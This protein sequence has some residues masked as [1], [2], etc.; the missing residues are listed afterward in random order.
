MSIREREPGNRGEATTTLNVAG[1]VDALALPS[2]EP[3]ATD[4]AALSGLPELPVLGE[5]GP[6]A[7]SQLDGVRALMDGCGDAIAALRRHQNRCAAEVAIMV[8]RMESTAVL[9]GKL[10]SLDWWQRGCAIDQ[11]TSELAVL[12]QVTE[13]VAGRLIEQSVTLVRLLP[14][15]LDRLAEGDL[16]WDHAVV[17]A[18]EA[19]LL[20]VSGVCQEAIDAFEKQLL[21]L[22]TN[23]TLPSFKSTARRIRERSHPESIVA[24]TRRSYADRNLRVNRGA[25]GM[26]WMALYAPSPTIEAIWDQCTYTAQAAQGADEDRTLTQLK[27]DIC[28]ALLLRQS[29]AENSIHSPARTENEAAFPDFGSSG[30][31]SRDEASATESAA[32]EAASAETAAGE[33]AA[34]ETASAASG[35]GGESVPR[36]FGPEPD[37]CGD[38]SCAD[39]GRG[40]SLPS[41]WQIPV[42]DDPDYTVSGFVE[43]DPRNYPDWRPVA[44]LPVLIPADP[45]VEAERLSGP[46]AKSA[47]NPSGDTTDLWPPLPQVTPVVLIPA[48]SLLGETNEPAWMDG[49]GPISMEVAKRMAVQAGSFLRVLVDPITNKPLDS[50]PDRYR[51]DQAMR[52]MLLIR[53]E[54]C[55]FPGCTAKAINC[56][57]DHIKSFE[58]GGR[59]I[60]NNLEHLCAHHHLVKHYK[61]DKDRTGTRR[62]IDEPERQSLRLRGWTPRREDDGRVSWTSPAGRY[63]PPEANEERNPAYPGWLK[64][65]IDGSLSQEVDG[66]P[67]G[68]PGRPSDP[69]QPDQ[70][71]Q[72]EEFASGREDDDILT[73]LALQRGLE[74]P[75]LGCAEAA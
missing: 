33:T 66:A 1:L 63:C 15:T 36:Y 48:L 32:G 5:S 26:S 38:G 47:C 54:Y 34:G 22:A 6:A 12:L 9:E 16:A 50:A 56:D 62:C 42:F 60:Y 30:S 49:A 68:A 57:V 71:D 18:E 29:M 35:A 31:S 24:R 40:D 75:W 11:I 64:G 51:I 46:P 65:V 3:L 45:P 59:S 58:S 4:I 7:W 25:D 69:N 39:Q 70:P 10:L 67:A 27:A 41:D 52:T 14:A 55:E 17:I 73:Q 43:P 23:K 53:D 72:P 21:G 44:Q 28:A 20:R 8:E 61:D 2:I 13:G 19:S 37:V 74:Q